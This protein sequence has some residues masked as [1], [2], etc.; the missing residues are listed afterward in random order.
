MSSNE[1]LTQTDAEKILTTSFFE[2][3]DS[4]PNNEKVIEKRRQAFGLLEKNGLPSRTIESWHYTDLRVLLKNL[5]NFNDSQQKLT[6]VT[7]YETDDGEIFH[8]GTPVDEANVTGINVSP[9]A[10]VVAGG[11][12][13]LS[14]NL[15]FDDTIGQINTSYFKDGWVIDIDPNA[16]IPQCINISNVS[17]SGQDHARINIRVGTGARCCFIEQHIAEGQTFGTSVTD[18][19]LDTNAEVTYVIMHA[20]ANEAINLAQFNAVLNQR[21]KLKVVLVDLGGR[22]MR[23]EANI[24]LVGGQ[25]DLKLRGINLLGQ[26]SRSDVTMVVRHLVEDTTSTEIMRNVVTGQAMGAF[27][28]LIRVAQQAQKTDAK[29]V[30]NSLI[31]SDNSEYNAKPE[32][33]IFADDVACGHGATV[34]EINEDNLFYLKAR[35]IAEPVARGMLIK[36]FVA[37]LIDEEKNESVQSF[38]DQSIE[39]WLKTHIW[40]VQ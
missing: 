27:Q 1:K 13:P 36:A 14:N 3:L 28:G 32:L 24:D 33:E 18:L 35:G 5:P 15:R 11:Q 37:E 25:S 29:M 23:Q 31:L 4:L 7:L 26:N 17:K 10:D 30:C 19:R 9:I 12:L 22:L 21:A 40:G 8:N 6:T 2:Y 34:A 39:N 38:L 16:T 20:G